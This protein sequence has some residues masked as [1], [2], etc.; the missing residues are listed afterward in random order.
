MLEH[1]VVLFRTQDG[2][3]AALEDRC[4]HR[5]APLSQG[6]LIGDDIACPYHGFRYNTRGACTLVPTQSHVPAALKVRSFPLREHGSFVWLWMGDP[7]SADPALLPDI[8]WFTNP[9]F[10]QLRGYTEVRCNYMA[11]Q[12]NVLDLTHI[13]H[14]HAAA[15]LEG[16]QQPPVEVKIT[17]RSVTILLDNLN[18]PVAPIL[19]IAMGVE[20]GK[21]VNSA[22]WGTFASPACHFSGMD[23]ED[24]AAGSG[25]RSRYTLR[26]MHCLT[27][28]SPNR[29]HYWWANAL[30]YGHH[31]PNLAEKL[32]PMN[33]AV[34]EQDKDILEAIETTIEQDVRGDSAPE[35]AVAADRAPVEARR[36]LAKMLEAE[37]L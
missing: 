29:C 30:D 31:V 13:P 33:E 22:T 24:P 19:A 14:L 12:E 36:I 27:P 26:A 16:F 10:V 20:P 23:I 1:R 5:W 4:A 25:Q 7:A 2:A 32:I 37:R 15:Q 18:V 8:P 3:I 6:R 9:D 34:I 35:M 11:I 21:N 17:D 28:I